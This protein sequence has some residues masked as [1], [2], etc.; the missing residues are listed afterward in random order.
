M[1]HSEE[2][3]D[4]YM[5]ELNN[6]DNCV[7]LF[8]DRADVLLQSRLARERIALLAEQKREE[9]EEDRARE[10]EDRKLLTE[11]KEKYPD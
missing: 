3:Y 4:I 11:L 10:I 9:Q 5:Y 6:K 7:P 8:F 2:G 1:E